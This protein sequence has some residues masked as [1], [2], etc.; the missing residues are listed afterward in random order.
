[1]YQRT[2]IKTTNKRIK[3]PYNLEEKSKWELI[4]IIQELTKS[5]K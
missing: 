2:K 3:W 1:M 5:A 4:Q